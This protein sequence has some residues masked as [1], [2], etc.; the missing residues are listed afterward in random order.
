MNTGIQGSS[1]TPLGA[2][3]PQRHQENQQEEKTW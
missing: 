1:S 2:S 3:T